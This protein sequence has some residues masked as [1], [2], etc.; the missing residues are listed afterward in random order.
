MPTKNLY[1]TL[2]E[3]KFAFGL[4]KHQLMRSL[5]EQKGIRRL[6]TLE[7]WTYHLPSI[8]GL[9][10]KQFRILELLQKAE[11]RKRFSFF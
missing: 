1:G 8:P 5:W 11:S 2:V 7:I 9:K 4:S 3:H 10:L 6:K